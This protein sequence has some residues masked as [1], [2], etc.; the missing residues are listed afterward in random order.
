MKNK[1][2]IIVDP[3]GFYHKMRGVVIADTG[4]IVTVLFRDG[5]T[6][7]FTKDVIEYP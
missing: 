1:K 3:H 7:E 4:L 6:M 2:V 5:D